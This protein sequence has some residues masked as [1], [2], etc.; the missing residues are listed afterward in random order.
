MTVTV[1]GNGGCLRLGRSGLAWN[2]GAGGSL[3]LT[4]IPPWSRWPLQQTLPHHQPLQPR[5]LR[6]L[7]TTPPGRKQASKSL[8]K[9]SLRGSWDAPWAQL[10]WLSLPN[11]LLRPDLPLICFQEAEIMCMLHWQSPLFAFWEVNIRGHT[12]H[13]LDWQRPYQAGNS[14]MWLRSSAFWTVPLVYR[15][16]ILAMASLTSM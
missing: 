11:P 3:L 1:A 7:R 12:T 4:V 6:R 15:K 8:F 14:C 13:E 16:E 9:K 10:R 2:D 5:Q